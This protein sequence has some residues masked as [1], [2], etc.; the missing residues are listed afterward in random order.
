MQIKHE[1]NFPDSPNL[2]KQPQWKKKLINKLLE[3]VSY[4]KFAK[5]ESTF[6]DIYYLLAKESH[7]ILLLHLYP[8]PTSTV[9]IIRLINRVLESYVI[10]YRYK[11]YL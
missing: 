7:V 4:P 11:K 6:T 8:N 9:N 1:P 5:R 10:I 2:I 3:T